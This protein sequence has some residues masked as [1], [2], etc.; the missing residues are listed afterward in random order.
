MGLDYV[1]THH[2]TSFRQLLLLDYHWFLRSIFIAQAL[3]VFGMIFLIETLM[4]K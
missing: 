1:C 3:V 4:R 2:L